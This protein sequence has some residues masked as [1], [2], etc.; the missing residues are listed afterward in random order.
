MASESPIERRPACSAVV[1]L[2]SHKWP[3]TVRF[4]PYRG[5]LYWDGM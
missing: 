1:D 5:D 2:D 3:D 4:I